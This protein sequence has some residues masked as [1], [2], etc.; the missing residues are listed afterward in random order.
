MASYIVCPCFLNNFKNRMRFNARRSE[1]RSLL[2]RNERIRRV[3][4]A[5]KLSIYIGKKS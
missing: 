5:G 1:F 4:L 2:S 3:N